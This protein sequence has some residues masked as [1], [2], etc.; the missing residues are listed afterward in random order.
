MP[1]LSGRGTGESEH[2]GY[3]CF[4]SESG[5]D[6]FAGAL[7]EGRVGGDTVEITRGDPTADW[8]VEA[9][10]F[11]EGQPAAI[12]GGQASRAAFTGAFGAATAE[13]PLVKDQLQGGGNG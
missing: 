4:I 12:T 2:P 11:D 13:Q 6:E 7:G 10:P 3:L 8:V 1:R 9:Q 5:S